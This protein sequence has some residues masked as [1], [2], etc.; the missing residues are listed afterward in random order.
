MPF[1]HG[2]LDTAMLKITKFVGQIGTHHFWINPDI[3]QLLSGGKDLPRDRKLA[4]TA[5]QKISLVLDRKWPWSSV[6]HHVLG[7]KGWVPKTPKSSLKSTSSP[8]PASSLS[9]S[10]G[11]RFIFFDGMCV[12]AHF[13]FMTPME[14]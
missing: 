6:S 11:I 12:M 8:F 13:L 9:V 1:E 3:I 5:G 2:D 10:L 7:P 4:R 14:K